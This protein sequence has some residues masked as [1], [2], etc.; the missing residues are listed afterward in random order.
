MLETCNRDDGPIGA[1]RQGEESRADL[2]AEGPGGESNLGRSFFTAEEE[3]LC[4]LRA[5]LMT[6]DFRA[7]DCERRRRASLESRRSRPV[8]FLLD[9]SS[10]RVI[11]LPSLP[12]R[13]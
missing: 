3:T 6:L 1:Q 12:S 11:Y 8:A 5:C 10:C 2:V 9:Q 4:Q 7:V 13:S